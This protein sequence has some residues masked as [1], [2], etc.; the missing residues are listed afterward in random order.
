MGRHRCDLRVRHLFVVIS[1]IRQWRQPASCL[2]S[3]RKGPKS[4]KLGG[5]LCGVEAAQGCR[6]TRPGRGCSLLVAR[7][8]GAARM[9]PGP[10]LTRWLPFN[11]NLLTASSAMY[12]S[13]LSG[14]QTLRS[15]SMLAT[16]CPASIKL[17]A[18]ASD[19]RACH[20]TCRVIGW[21]P[22]QMLKRGSEASRWFTVGSSKLTGCGRA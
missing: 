14:H 10:A 6:W 5:L 21:C 7:H 4:S 18:P 16:S 19:R 1:S 9:L 2:H 17:L 3:C 11:D 13:S 15:V 22:G 12:S 20:L 8:Q